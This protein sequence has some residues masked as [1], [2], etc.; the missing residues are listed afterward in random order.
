MYRI[1]LHLIELTEVSFLDISLL[2]IK[3][4]IKR[5]THCYQLEHPIPELSTAQTSV[6]RLLLHRSI[7]MA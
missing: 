6:T 7:H 3:H 4:V 2:F 5:V 1:L